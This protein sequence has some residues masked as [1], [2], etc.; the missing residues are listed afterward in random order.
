MNAEW[1]KNEGRN[2]EGDKFLF[3]D[4]VGEDGR[5]L[6]T[7]ECP[8]GDSHQHKCEI[9]IIGCFSGHSY[10]N[11]T[12]AMKFCETTVDEWIALEQ[13]DINIHREHL[14]K[15]ARRRAAPLWKRLLHIG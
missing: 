7:V 10:T 13:E 14:T 4:Y 11:A 2:Q 6:A 15:S 12:A 3:W 1:I 5:I 9:N 8:I